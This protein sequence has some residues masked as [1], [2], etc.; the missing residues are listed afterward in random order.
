MP[1]VSE[2]YGMRIEARTR[3]TVMK[4]VRW[5][6]FFGGLIA[7]MVVGVYLLTGVGK[8]QTINPDIRPDVARALKTS[9]RRGSHAR[10]NA[11]Q[12]AHSVMQLGLRPRTDVSSS[13]PRIARASRNEAITP[14][15]PIS[16]GTALS[17]VLH[18]S[19]LNLSLNS[20]AGT[21][22][23]FVDR[24]NDLVADDRTTF[25]S[26]GGSFDIAVGKSGTRYEVFSATLNNTLI[27]V[28][29]IANDTNGDFVANFSSTLDLHRQERRAMV[30]SS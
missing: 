7:A 1:V 8:A 29:V 17:R 10:A 12:P 13:S 4:T 22:E 15:A 30:V 25:D 18:T 28:L 26:A 6:S 9:I 24:N 19:Q 16:T 14:T 5:V 23:Q 3:E 21:D 2:T 27:G 20:A 11:Y